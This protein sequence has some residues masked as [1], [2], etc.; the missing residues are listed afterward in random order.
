MGRAKE[1]RY[2]KQ[3]LLKSTTWRKIKIWRVEK[4]CSF[5]LKKKEST[6][7]SWENKI[8]WG[9]VSDPSSQKN[10]FHV[11]F[12]LFWVFLSTENDSRPVDLE[13]SGFSVFKRNFVECLLEK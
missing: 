6:E 9:S 7:T 3:N 1:L 12:D 5:R 11:Y 13:P 10:I 2:L 8:V 4:S